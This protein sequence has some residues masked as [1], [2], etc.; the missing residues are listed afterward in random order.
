MVE[1]KQLN[2]K[3]GASIYAVEMRD[4]GIKNESLDRNIY[5]GSAHVLF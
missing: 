5:D 4:V 1:L 3:T 2:Q